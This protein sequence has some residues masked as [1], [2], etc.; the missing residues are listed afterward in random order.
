MVGPA[1]GRQNQS[2]G[3]LRRSAQGIRVCSQY[4]RPLV[5]Q[6]H[7]AITAAGAGV[8]AGAETLAEIPQMATEMLSR[9]CP[10]DFASLGQTRGPLRS[11]CPTAVPSPVR[12]KNG[13]CKGFQACCPTACPSRLPLPGADGAHRAHP[14]DGRPADA[15]MADYLDHQS[16]SRT[17]YARCAHGHSSRGQSLRL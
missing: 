5:R 6:R 12:R 15:H 9:H 17:V 4:F 3:Q 11:T 8:L 14:S 16:R 13:S 7:H 2:P 10:A 1:P